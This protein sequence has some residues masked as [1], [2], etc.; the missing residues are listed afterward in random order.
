MQRG[1]PDG[2]NPGFMGEVL[3]VTAGVEKEVEGMSRLG[4]FRLCI[5]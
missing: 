2:L 4:G 5:V 3:N 1:T